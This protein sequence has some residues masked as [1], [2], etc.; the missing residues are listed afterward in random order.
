M[1][2]KVA[3]K[4]M[5]FGHGIK[6]TVE[7]PYT[8][9][10]AIEEFKT[11]IAG[12]GGT[13]TTVMDEL[14]VTGD[15]STKDVLKATQ[16]LTENLKGAASPLDDALRN[17]GKSIGLDP[18]FVDRTVDAKSPTGRLVSE[19]G[20]MD[21]ASLERRAYANHPFGYPSFAHVAPKRATKKVKDVVLKALSTWEFTSQYLS[22]VSGRQVSLVGQ[23]HRTSKDRAVL[24]WKREGNMALLVAEPDNPFDLNAVMVL[25]WNDQTKQ[26]HH[27]GYVRA[28]QA[29]ILRGQWTGDFKNAMVARFTHIPVKADG[30]RD[31][32]N[33]Q[34]TLTGEVRTYPG[35]K[36]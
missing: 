15:L 1:T 12:L 10:D 20:Y 22:R 24:N 4:T 33:I 26:W 31:G 35:Y 8:T 29:A 27:V 25:A 5:D 30:H 28:T 21:F 34:L 19:P 7:R 36:L 18:D 14:V 17:Y 2:N 23:H 6:V 3:R 16:K 32:R 13:V 9:Q 11:E